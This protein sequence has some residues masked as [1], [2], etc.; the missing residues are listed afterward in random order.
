MVS[1]IVWGVVITAAAALLL[2]GAVNRTMAR[3]ETGGS[4]AGLAGQQQRQGQASNN[5]VAGESG[6]A[7][8]QAEGAGVGLGGD[9]QGQGPG[10]RK[11]SAGEGQAYSG[12]GQGQG[13]GGGRRQGEGNGAIAEPLADI[14]ELDTLQGIVVEVNDELVLLE[15]ESGETLEIGGRAWRFALENGFTVRQQERLQVAGFYDEGHFE[16]ISIRN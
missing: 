10:Q 14:D 4:T 3:S 12:Q 15:Q 1:R 13:Q 11:Q 7:A 6:Y 2:V 16:P 8:G 9:G 5:Q